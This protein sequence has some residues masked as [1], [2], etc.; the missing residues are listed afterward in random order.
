MNE[1]LL[2]YIVTLSAFAFFVVCPRLGA[3]TNLLNRHSPFSIYWLVILGTFAS[4]PMLI[5]MTW[6]IRHWGLMAGLGL[7]IATDLAAAVTL[8]SI[9]TKV[10]VETFIIA[11]FV[12]V[13]NRVATWI[14]SSFL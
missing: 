1:S 11:L 6:M 13:G 9:S 12:V 4:I 8:T 14:G 7:A 3:M 5:L 2:S 10:A